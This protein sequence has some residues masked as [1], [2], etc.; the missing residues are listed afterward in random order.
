MFLGMPPTFQHFCFLNCCSTC[1]P[2]N[3]LFLPG[4][5]DL[6]TWSQ[7]THHCLLSGEALRGTSSQ[8]SSFVS[9]QGED[10]FIYSTMLKVSSPQIRF[11]TKC[12][13]TPF[14]QCQDLPGSQTS[15]PLSQMESYTGRSMDPLLP[16]GEPGRKKAPDSD[17]DVTQRYRSERHRP[18]VCF[19]ISLSLISAVHYVLQYVMKWL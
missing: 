7:E 16:V 1:S 6:P 11:S 5:K 17:Y 19:V 2:D 14:L 12:V 18:H 10:C 4:A 15:S 8:A 9:D 3:F 13:A